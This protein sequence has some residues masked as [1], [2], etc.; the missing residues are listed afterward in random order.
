[1]SSSRDPVAAELAGD[2]AA[3]MLAGQSDV[4]D[5]VL[6]ANRVFVAVAAGA[7]ADVEPEVT[8]PQFRALVLCEMHGTITVA[9]LAAAMGVVP[10]TATRMCDRLVA[11][12]LLDRATDEVNRRQ[13]N[14]RLRPEGRTLIDQSTRKRTDEI[15]QLL[16]VIPPED[17]ARLTEGLALLVEAAHGSDRTRP[18]RRPLAGRGGKND[19]ERDA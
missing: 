5:A 11:K 1:M 4:V 18:S 3:T 19:Q 9:E 8:L 15:G 14:L 13:V 17:Q 16:A 2:D 6:A 10:S 12:K 7:L